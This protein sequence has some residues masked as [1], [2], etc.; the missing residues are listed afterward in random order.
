[1]KQRSMKDALRSS[2]NQ[3]DSRFTKA[4]SFF[5]EPSPQQ[6]Q[7]SKNEKPQPGRGRAE[8]EDGT[9]KRDTFTFP[10]GDYELIGLIK[11]RCL[12]LGIETN[13]S[14][15]LRVALHV[16]SSSS[17]SS[18]QE[19]FSKIEKVKTGRRKK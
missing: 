14:E 7:R 2:L 17:D 19:S 8:D 18:L 4:D 6:Q 10:A 11:T 5:D 1:M 15:I 16:L 3:E 13:K 12:Q 9:V